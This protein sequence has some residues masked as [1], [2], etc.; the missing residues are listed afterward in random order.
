MKEKKYHLY[1]DY[2]KWWLI[3][4]RLINLWNSLTAEGRYTDCVGELIEK[5][6]HARIVKVKI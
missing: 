6:V 3:I 2:N 5:L 1:L 4:L